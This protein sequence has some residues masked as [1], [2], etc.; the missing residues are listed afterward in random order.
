MAK[1]L[2]LWLGVTLVFFTAFVL[3]VGAA[4]KETVSLTNV[5]GQ[6]EATLELPAPPM[7]EIVA[8]QLSFQIEAG[9]GNIGKED[10]SF[11]FDSRLPEGV[12]QQSRY[13]E[14]T[15][16]L[17]IYISGNQDLYP[18]GTTAEALK[19]S[20][21]RVVVDTNKD[22]SVKVIKNSFKTVNRAHGMYEGEVNTGDG[23]ETINNGST[24]GD[25]SNNQRPGNVENNFGTS[26]GFV[27]TD[28]ENNSESPENNVLLVEEKKNEKGSASGSL[29]KVM[30]TAE[31]LGVESD[32]PEQDIE[33]E[34]SEDLPIPEDS[35]WEEGARIWKEKTGSVD[36][37]VWTK[38][39]FGLFVVSAVVASTIGI[40]LSIQ[41]SKKRKRRKRKRAKTVELRKKQAVR[42]TQRK[43][44]YKEQP[45]W[46]DNK[47][48]YVRKRRKVS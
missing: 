1:R 18:K 43:S 16:I 27:K 33:K 39:F 21:G 20:L 25:T 42:G 41:A 4:E 19:L 37:D 3:S 26:E 22:A 47:K 40:S 10:V 13:Q 12:L 14:D 30:D 31:T 46:K 34:D 8:L 7:E 23:G 24:G 5:D 35:L 17:T 44:S 2:M 32:L 38:I 45:V 9:Q 28:G 48:S 29:K 6:I 15:G 36:M 11:A